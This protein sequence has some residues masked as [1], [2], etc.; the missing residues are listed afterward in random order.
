M[1]CTAQ[2]LGSW[3]GWR[4]SGSGP[5][6]GSLTHLYF[7]QAHW[8]VYFFLVTWLVF[9]SSRWPGLFASFL[10]SSTCLKVSFSSP[11]SLYMLGGGVVIMILFR[12]FLNLFSDV[13]SQSLRSFPAGGMLHHPLDHHP[14]TI[15]WLSELPSRVG[16]VGLRG[17]SSQGCG[18]YTIFIF[19]EQLYSI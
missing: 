15:L 19:W 2:L 5:P 1:A 14:L 7:F 3:T 6:P 10:G 9:A 17:K 18:T 12:D 16:S 8:M 13:C 4:F 11:Y